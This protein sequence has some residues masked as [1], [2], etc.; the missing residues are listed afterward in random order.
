MRDSRA[1]QS[2]DDFFKLQYIEIQPSL[3]S[4]TGVAWFLLLGTTASEA[5]LAL[6]SEFAPICV[7]K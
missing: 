5:W 6:E 2:M 1:C 4:C 3:P 7:W